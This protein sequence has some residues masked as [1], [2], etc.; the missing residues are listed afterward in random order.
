MIGVMLTTKHS[1]VNLGNYEVPDSE[2]TTFNCD[3]QPTVRSAVLLGKFWRIYKFEEK[4]TQILEK[5]MD[6]KQP[7]FF[8]TFFLPFH[9]ALICGHT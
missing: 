3:K 7:T 2:V 8:T 4:G 1:Q 6:I 9:F 5:S